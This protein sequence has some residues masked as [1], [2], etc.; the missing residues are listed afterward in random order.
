MKTVLIPVHD[1]TITKNLLRT[2]FLKVLVQNDVRVVLI[3]QQREKLEDYVKEFSIPHRVIVEV[4]DAY[5]SPSTITNIFTYIFR[6]SIPT[7]FMKIRQVDWYWNQGKYVSYYLSAFLRV[8]G[9]SS[10]W[11]KILLHISDLEPIHNPI[12]QLFTRWNPDV[13]FAPTMLSEAEVGL[14]RLSKKRK[15]ICIGMA[16]S[17]DNLTSKAYLRVHPDYLIVPNETCKQEAINLYNYDERKIRVTGISQYD[18]YKDIDDIKIEK[19]IFFKKV[20]L[21]PAKKTILYAPAGDW[22]NPTDHEVLGIILDWIDKGELKNTQVLL[23]LH[24]SYESKTE[25]LEGYP[26]LVVERPG[27]HY[28]TLKS[29]E[30]EREDVV[31]LA[32]SLYHADVVIQTASTLMVEGGIL[33]TPVI[34]VGFDGYKK[35]NYWQSVIRYYDREHLLSVVKAGGAPVVKN[36]HELLS[37]IKKYFDT[38]ETHTNERKKSVQLVCGVI[39]GQ[40]SHRTA[41]VVLEALGKTM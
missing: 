5:R 1:G 15:K 25:S 31:H 9:A 7:T 16:K 6:H 8:L 22:M 33:G 29:Y 27:K 19:N 20:G 32:N 35:R 3:V 34:S 24:P 38:P 21:S 2:D 10:I 28:G 4:S 36:K 18:I 17:F 23:R 13:V 14:M 26:A 39:D 40:A 30:F 41:N 12:E 37:L 11:K